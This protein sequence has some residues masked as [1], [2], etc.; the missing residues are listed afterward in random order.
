[1]KLATTMT[2]LTTI[3]SV[4]AITSVDGIVTTTQLQPAPLRPVAPAVGHKTV[5]TTAA[6]TLTFEPLGDHGGPC[7]VGHQLGQ[8]LDTAGGVRRP[9]R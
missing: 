8:H 2:V 6:A 1:M 5:R 3:S 7:R 4:L 9:M